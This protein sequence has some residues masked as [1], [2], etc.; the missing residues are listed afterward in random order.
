MPTRRI[1]LRIAK[2]NTDDP[3]KMMSG[4]WY[5]HADGGWGE[6]TQAKCHQARGLSVGRP[7]GRYRRN[8]DPN[9]AHRYHGAEYYIITQPQKNALQKKRKYGQKLHSSV[10]NSS[11]QG[12]GKWRVSMRKSEK[13]G[14]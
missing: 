12:G 10:S 14:E 7:T 13:R 11:I 9:R 5:E 6:G 4:W 1:I 2:K 8:C 3:L